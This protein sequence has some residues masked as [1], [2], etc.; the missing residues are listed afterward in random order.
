MENNAKKLLAKHL[1][2]CILRDEK[3]ELSQKSCS[4]LP[5]KYCS[6]NIVNEWCILDSKGNK[7]VY[8][9]DDGPYK[10]DDPESET[11][12]KDKSSKSSMIL[13]SISSIYLLLL[14]L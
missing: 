14:M 3:C 2:E 10:D 13:F 8:S 5:I 4:K 11:K 12:D 9:N 6:E 7:C 1:I